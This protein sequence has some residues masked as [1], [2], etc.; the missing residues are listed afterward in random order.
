MKDVTIFPIFKQNAPVWNDFLNIISHTMQS[1][2][3][4]EDSKRVHARFI[5]DWEQPAHKFAFGAYDN[6]K[7]VGFTSG[8]IRNQVATINCL[9]VL[10]KYQKQHIGNRLLR[11]TESA[12]SI[13]ARQISLTALADACEF[14]KRNKYIS[15]THTNEFVKTIKKSGTCS[16]SPVFFCTKQL[17]KKCQEIA[18]ING[19][20]LQPYDIKKNRNPM[21]IYRDVNLEITAFG[22]A[23]DDIIALGK[24][25][26]ADDWATSQVKCKIL[27]YLEHTK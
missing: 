15:P 10:P 18:Q 6:G 19:V 1:T 21:F 8:I 11:A 4:R 7:M 25:T 26:R 13:N 9:Y 2:Y 27:N 14:Y 5:H 20:D 3:D 23:G 16:V 22:I 17:M 24:N 12:V